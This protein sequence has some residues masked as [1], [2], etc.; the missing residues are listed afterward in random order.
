MREPLPCGDE[1]LRDWLGLVAFHTLKHQ[2]LNPKPETL[3]SLNPKP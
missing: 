2:T 3:N 1:A